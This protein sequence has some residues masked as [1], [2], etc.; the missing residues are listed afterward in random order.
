MFL[1]EESLP[2]PILSDI[3]AGRVFVYF[4]TSATENIGGAMHSLS[5]AQ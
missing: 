5:R 2:S 1:G 4:Q 3:F